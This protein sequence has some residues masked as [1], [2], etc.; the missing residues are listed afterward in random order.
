MLPNAF[1]ADPARVR[2][3]QGDFCAAPPEKL[4]TEAERL[5]AF[6]RSLADQQWQ[7]LHSL[8][9]PVLVIHG[10]H[11]AIPVEAALALAAALP[12]GL[13]LVIRGADHLPWIEQPAQFFPAAEQFFRGAWP[14]A[15][16]VVP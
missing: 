4:R 6:Q 15:A 3:I 1:L 12:E 10:D 16:E 11:D 13:V 2:R 14:S 8:P 7:A 9:V 5:A